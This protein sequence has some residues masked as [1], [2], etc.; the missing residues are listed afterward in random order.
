MATLLPTGAK[1]DFTPAGRKER[2]DF[3]TI[4]YSTLILPY[5]KIFLRIYSSIL[6]YFYVFL[7]Y[8]I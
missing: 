3:Q 8:F 6:R 1:D 7:R 2:F 4:R 5:F